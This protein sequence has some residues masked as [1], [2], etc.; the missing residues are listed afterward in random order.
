MSS[1]YLFDR[2]NM[3]LFAMLKTCFSDVFDIK[4][5]FYDEKTDIF[6]GFCVQMIFY[7]FTPSSIC[8]WALL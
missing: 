7:I 8:F 3:S 4:A 1:F 2:M 5:T 6:K